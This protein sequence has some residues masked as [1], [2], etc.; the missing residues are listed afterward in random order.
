MR[1]PPSLNHRF[2]LVQSILSVEFV[3][4]IFPMSNIIEASWIV[5]VDSIEYKLFKDEARSAR[6]SVVSNQPVDPQVHD[7]A[8]PASQEVQTL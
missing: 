8:T 6:K 3:E 1:L 7:V 4:M 2:L 5:L